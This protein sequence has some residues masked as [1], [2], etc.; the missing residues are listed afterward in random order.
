MRFI[1]AASEGLQRLIES[2]AFLEDLYYRLRS[3]RI[4]VPGLR[5]RREDIPGLVDQLAHVRAA[6]AGYFDTP[7]DFD[8]SVMRALTRAPWPGNLRELGDSVLKLMCFAQG[9]RKVTLAHCRGDLTYLVD[10][11]R[12]GRR[13]PDSKEVEEVVERSSGNRSEAARRLGVSRSTIQRRLRQTR[14]QEVHHV[15]QNT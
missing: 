8:G 14:R 10:L 15:E 6:E 2:G 3:F 13:R 9:A 11:A 7:P 5:D 12:V 4:M 1:A